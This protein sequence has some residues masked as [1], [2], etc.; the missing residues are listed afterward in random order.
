[1]GS[2]YAVS[3]RL[4]AIDDGLSRDFPGVLS[5]FTVKNDL[6]SGVSNETKKTIHWRRTDCGCCER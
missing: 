3:I 6:P 1:M 4:S 2:E 5:G